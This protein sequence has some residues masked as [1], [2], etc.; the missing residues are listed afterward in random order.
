VKE[1]GETVRGV[2]DIVQSIKKAVD[3]QHDVQDALA[4]KL[5]QLG[6]MR[7]DSS[8]KV[9]SGSGTDFVTRDE[10]D[11]RLKALEED[12]EEVTE[13]DVDD[14]F[15]RLHAKKHRL[16]Y[17]KGK[18]RIQD[19]F[20]QLTAESG[21]GEEEEDDG[22]EAQGGEDVSD[23]VSGG[24]GGDGEPLTGD[25]PGSPAPGATSTDADEKN[26]DAPADDQAHEEAESEPEE[27]DFSDIE[28]VVPDTTLRQYRDVQTDC[29]GN[30]ECSAIVERPRQASEKRRNVGLVC[31]II[32][33]KPD[34]RSRIRS[35]PK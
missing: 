9:P 7:G 17:R 6:E 33:K 13:E 12:L 2:T 22:E 8:E 14:S 3:R 5:S 34:R 31:A 10:L 18:R 21:Q 30:V 23:A 24:A 26:G 1:M 27:V 28:D 29:S 25:R 19:E 32:P 20:Q 35:S 15:S 4:A 11:E 16:G